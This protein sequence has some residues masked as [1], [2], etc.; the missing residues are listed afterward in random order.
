MLKPASQQMSSENVETAQKPTN[1]K[2]LL[3]Y[4]DPVNDDHDYAIVTNTANLAKRK[5]ACAA[6]ATPTKPPAGKKSRGD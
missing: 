5:V 1:P 6:P 3:A 2:N 4:P